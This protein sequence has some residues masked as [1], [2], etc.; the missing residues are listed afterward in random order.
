MDSAKNFVPWFS[1]GRK[2]KDVDELL[3]D[4]L[5]L[6]VTGIIIHGRPDKRYVYWSYQHLKGNANLNIECMRRAL[7]HALHTLGFRPK[8]H[9]QFD[10]ASDNRN[11]TMIALGEW[12]VDQGL[13][14]KVEFSMLPV[15]HTHEDIDAMFRFIA[16]SLRR[17]GLV[18][19]PQEFEMCTKTA[20]S[21]GI[22]VE[23]VSWVRYSIL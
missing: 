1:S 21:E 19:T 14:S 20:V 11:L 23:H 5:K 10:G 22:H 15:G 3:K 12:L 17:V 2:P 8:L 16:D 9:V 7:A 6:H 18:R 13:V 4:V